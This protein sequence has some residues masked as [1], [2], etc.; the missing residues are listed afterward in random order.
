VAVRTRVCPAGTI[1]IPYKIR[2]RDE[3]EER[4]L[5]FDNPNES[6]LELEAAESEGCELVPE[7]PAV[8]GTNSSPSNLNPI[9]DTDNNSSFSEDMSEDA[10][11][12]SETTET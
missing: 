5:A 3:I 12:L 1:S 11:E 6:P 10:D 7:V 9:S 4:E 8:E 2:G